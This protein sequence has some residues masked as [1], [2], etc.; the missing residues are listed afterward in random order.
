MEKTKLTR[1]A[2]A[3]LAVGLAAQAAE[4]SQKNDPNTKAKSSPSAGRSDNSDIIPPDAKQV[5]AHTWMAPDKDG[6]KWFYRQTPF[7]VVKTDRDPQ[8]KTDTVGKRTPFD[9]ASPA[10]RSA[11]AEK[12]MRPTVKVTDLGDSYAFERQTPFG[13]SRWTH[14][15]SELTDGDKELLKIA[16]PEAPATAA[17]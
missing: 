7:G 8:A 3:I 6:K 11:A 9:G 16:K 15:K 14:K 2:L 10:P 5:D 12:S 4:T 17:K 1:I 13:P